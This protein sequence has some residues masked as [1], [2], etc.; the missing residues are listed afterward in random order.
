PS[1]PPGREAET[2]PGRS[3]V[4]GLTIGGPGH[5]PTPAAPTS[6]QHERSTGDVGPGPGSDPGSRA[7]PGFLARPTAADAGSSLDAWT[8]TG[9]AGLVAGSGPATSPRR[10]RD[11]RPQVAETPPE[12]ARTPE[13]PAPVRA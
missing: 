11:I 10:E 1:S 13:P 2:E 5:R 4:E 6:P 12:R 3:G 7:D 8:A 9:G